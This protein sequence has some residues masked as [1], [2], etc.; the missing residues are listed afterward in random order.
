MEA[1]LIGLT[2]NLGLVKLFKEFVDFVTGKDTET[3][4]VY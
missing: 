3:Q 4:I 2:N 1:E